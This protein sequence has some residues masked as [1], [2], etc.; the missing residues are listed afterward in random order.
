[1]PRPRAMILGCAGEA[2]D[3]GERSFMADADPAGFI[4]FKRNCESPAQDAGIDRG[5]P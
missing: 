3:D 2:L 4:L 1:M 5:S